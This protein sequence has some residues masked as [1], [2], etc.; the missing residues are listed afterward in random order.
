MKTYQI[1]IKDV[2]V[3]DWVLKNDKPHQITI[4]DLNKLED[5]RIL[6]RESPFTPMPITQEIL[7]ENCTSS[8]TG[9]KYLKTYCFEDLEVTI[10]IP[11]NFCWISCMEELQFE[12]VHELQALLFAFGIDV[13][14]KI[15]S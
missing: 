1:T 2:R 6:N 14:I 10:S 4:A 11:I 5:Y 12:F 8:S 13:T 9:D 7:E 15:N 3:G